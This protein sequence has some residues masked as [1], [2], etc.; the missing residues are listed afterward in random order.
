EF[1][2][3]S[4]RANELYRIFVVYGPDRGL[5]SERAALL[6]NKSGIAKDDPFAT[7]KLDAAD[8]LNDPGRLLDEVNALGLF[9]GE[10]LVWLRNTSN[11]KAVVDALR[12]LSEAPPPVNYLIIEAGDL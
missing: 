9:G 3:F 2:R 4:K 10:K 7:L 5:V 8:L 11:E 12:H 1:E 6:V